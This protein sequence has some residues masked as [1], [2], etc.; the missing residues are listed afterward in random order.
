MELESMVSTISGQSAQTQASCAS[1]MVAQGFF[2]AAM[3]AVFVFP[4]VLRA[5]LQDTHLQVCHD[6]HQLTLTTAND[7]LT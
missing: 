4:E 2:F 6:Q 3:K 7:I 1:L 5:V